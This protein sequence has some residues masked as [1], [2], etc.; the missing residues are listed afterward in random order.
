MAGTCADGDAEYAISLQKFKKLYPSFDPD[1]QE[2]AITIPGGPK[3]PLSAWIFFLRDER[4]QK[5][6]QLG[7]GEDKGIEFQVPPKLLQ[8]SFF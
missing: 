1:A 6:Q 3:R 5:M 2:G 8:V 7:P 4:Q